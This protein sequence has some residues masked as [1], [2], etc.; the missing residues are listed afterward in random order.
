MGVEQEGRVSVAA[1]RK[2]IGQGGA[3][4]KRRGPAGAQLLAWRRHHAANFGAPMAQGT[5]S[6]TRA[7]SLD[8]DPFSPAFLAEPYCDHA[9]L[10]DAG[11]VVYLAR[12]GIYAMA[13][14]E[15]VA[16]ALNDWQTYSSARGV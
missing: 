15:D 14:Y 16:A 7:P 11:P 9:R 4:P 2:S 5:T 8:I 3:V 13:R 6:L 10:R 12:Y 1:A